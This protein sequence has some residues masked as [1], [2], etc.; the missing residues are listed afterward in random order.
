MR[1]ADRL[2]LYHSSS[3]DMPAKERERRI[4]RKERERG[5]SMCVQIESTVSFFFF[6]GADL[7]WISAA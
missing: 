2:L 4:E 5:I 6:L 1:N 3:G 7:L